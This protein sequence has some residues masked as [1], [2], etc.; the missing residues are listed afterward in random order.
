MIIAA[1]T[2]L[3][4]GH[5]SMTISEEFKLDKLREHKKKY[6]LVNKAISK[7]HVVNIQTNLAVQ[8]HTNLKHVIHMSNCTFRSRKV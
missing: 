5:R 4:Y 8:S 7:K 3:T 1:L 6:C 2:I